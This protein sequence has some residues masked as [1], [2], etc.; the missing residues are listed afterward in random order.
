L[1]APTSL[2]LLQQ[3]I[4]SELRRLKLTDFK[5]VD[6]LFARTPE[7]LFALENLPVL[8]TVPML[9]SFNTLPVLL[10]PIELQTVFSEMQKFSSTALVGAT[11][12]FTV[13]E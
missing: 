10:P 7:Y 3:A 1:A 12:S 4:R 9:P 13:N 6:A 8:P 11:S 5:Q 2:E